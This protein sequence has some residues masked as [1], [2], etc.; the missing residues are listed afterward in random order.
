LKTKYKKAIVTGG[1]G[2]VGSHIVGGL[3][4]EGLEVI[5]VDD[6]SSGKKEN[7][8][9]FH[10]MPGFHEVQCDVTDYEKMKSYFHGV[11]LVCHNAASKKTICL[12]DPR[13]D[14]EVNAK[15]TFNILQLSLEYGVKKVVHASTGSVYGEALYFPQDE[16]HPLNPLSYYGVSKLAGERYAMVFHALY[17]LDVTVLRYFHVYGPYQDSS[18]RGG[19]VAIFGRRVL[20]GKHPV[21]FGDGSQQRSFTYVQDVVAVNKLVAMIP[22]TGGE[23]FNCA[24]GISVSIGELAAKVETMLERQ[25]L[26]IEYSDW[27]PGDIKVFNI[28]NSKLARLGFQSWTSFEKGLRDTL[29]WLKSCPAS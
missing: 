1:A 25:D 2:F 17:G 7:L 8:A 18:D 9:R 6:Y 12:Q 23:V 15:G 27:T 10:D 21:I 4:D 22:D 20:D 19:V 11:D 29:D 26:G 28:D 13:R 3:L 24:S 14:L 16:N 5:S